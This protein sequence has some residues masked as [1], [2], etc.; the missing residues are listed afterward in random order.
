M[1]VGVR[2]LVMLV[3]LLTACGEGIVPPEKARGH[4][5]IGETGCTQDADCEP[6]ARCLQDL[7]TPLPP[8][9]EPTPPGSNQAHLSAA[10]LSLN[11]GVVAPGTSRRLGL[12]L[13]NDGEAMVTLEGA[14]IVPAGSPFTLEQ[15]GTGPFWV[16]PGRGRELFVRYTPA[17]AGLHQATLRLSSQA[18]VVEIPLRG[19]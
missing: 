16:R 11:F 12:V 14:E 10:P 9:T 4:A 13:S 18:P 17:A 8:G 6:N 19:D 7:C 15:L 2:P 5:G 1:T 3:V